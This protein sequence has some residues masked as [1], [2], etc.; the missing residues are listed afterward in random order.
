MG[1]DSDTDVDAGSRFNYAFI[2]SPILKNFKNLQ[3][4]QCI[5]FIKI[6]LRVI[7]KDILI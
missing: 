7:S 6:T 3:S 2:H 1:T 4:L 5:E